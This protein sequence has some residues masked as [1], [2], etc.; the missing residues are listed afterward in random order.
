MFWIGALVFTYL[1]GVVFSVIYSVEI[2]PEGEKA[3]GFVFGLFFGSFWPLAIFLM[4]FG[5]KPNYKRRI[6]SENYSQQ[7][8]QFT[9]RM[10][11]H[12]FKYRK[13]KAVQI[14]HSR[15]IELELS[16]L[17]DLERL[18]GTA[19]SCSYE[20]FEGVCPSSIPVQDV[21]FKYKNE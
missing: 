7:Q 10:I 2:S 1:S 4:I 19:H 15:I 5:P 21:E 11:L 8:V 20:I 16:E 9:V 17:S 12:P 3:D 18:N 13:Q 6:Q 14:R